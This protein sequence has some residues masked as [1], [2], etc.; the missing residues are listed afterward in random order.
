MLGNF[1]EA[2]TQLEPLSRSQPS[3]AQVFDLLAKAYDG[4][5]KKDQAERAASKAKEL[6]ANSQR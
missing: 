5:G 6:S 2:V 1:S 3:Q 4:M